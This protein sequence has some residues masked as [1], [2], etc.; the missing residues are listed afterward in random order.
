MDDDKLEKER[1]ATFQLQG[2]IA[3]QSPESGRRT[4]DALNTICNTII[5]A[6]RV[7]NDASKDRHEKAD[8]IRAVTSLSDDLDWLTK[9]TA[10]ETY[11]ARLYP[12]FHEK[13]QAL[14]EDIAN[15]GKM[16][17]AD[18]Q[19]LEQSLE[20]FPDVFDL[21]LGVLEN[22]TEFMKQCHAVEVCRVIDAGKNAYAETE[23]LLNLEFKSNL[24]DQAKIMSSRCTDFWKST[25][26]LVRVQD[27]TNVA[28]ITRV[29]NV[30]LLLKQAMPNLILTTKEWL[31]SDEDPEA[32][33]HQKQA[34]HDVISCL[35][36]IKKILERV[37]VK[38]TSA[39]D[40]DATKVSGELAPVDKALNDVLKKVAALRSLPANAPE[41]DRRIAAEGVPVATKATL[42]EFDKLHAR[43]DDKAS[44]VSS[45]KQAR[46][47]PDLSDYFGAQDALHD[48]VEKVKLSQPAIV[49]PIPIIS[50]A[51]PFID[52]GPQDLL[53]VAKKMCDALK[54]LNLTLD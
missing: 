33:E 16:L 20:D 1:R 27:D 31:F 10:E 35:D 23:N 26:N 2:V 12:N 36:E 7:A 21:M 49:A 48:L 34:Y 24:V 14:S 37:K 32:K 30:E 47:A 45:V 28:L 51:V 29:E 40:E 3:A 44:L 43:P 9:F 22:M 15:Q 38:Y 54:N 53:E 39:F 19:R 5:E 18:F 46:D 52:E 42:A 17:K 8:A 6:Y 41:E 25:N 11:A 13:L 4:H 50:S